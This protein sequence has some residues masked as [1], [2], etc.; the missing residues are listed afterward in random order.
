MHYLVYMNVMDAQTPPTHTITATVRLNE[1]FQLF[2]ESSYPFFRSAVHLFLYLSNR[3]ISLC[4]PFHWFK[5][6][7]MQLILQDINRKPP[8]KKKTVAEVR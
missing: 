1:H 5:Y 3:T 2:R 6:P 7:L 4:I 8:E